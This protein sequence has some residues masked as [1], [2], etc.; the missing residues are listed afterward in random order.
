M[1]HDVI[2][3]GYGCRLLPVEV[4]DAEFIIHIRT[5]DHA[6]G[7][8][9]DTSASVD[10]QADWIRK[11]HERENDYYW[12]IVDLK[13]NQKVGTIGLYD[14]DKDS[15]MPGRW[16]LL[17]NINFMIASPVILVYQ[18]AFSGLKL[19]K[20]FFNVVAENKKVLKFH[21]LFGATETHREKNGQQINGESVDFIWFEITEMEWQA[22][23]DKWDHLLR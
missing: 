6:R 21:R 13:A 8:I 10:A 14:I 11:Y 22:I 3:E 12:V 18:F 16:V 9:G 23:Y 19:K 2:L 7:F 20:L 15:G 4:N 1:K 5:L 17:P